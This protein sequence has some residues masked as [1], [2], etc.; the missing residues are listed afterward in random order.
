MASFHSCHSINFKSII[1]D[2]I[3]LN[4]LEGIGLDY[5]WKRVGHRL[6]CILTP[7]IITKFWSFILSTKC[8]SFYKLTT[9]LPKLKIYDRFTIVDEESG[10][11][12]EPP[13]LL[14]GPYEYCPVTGEY[15][16]CS[17]Y[18][19]RLLIPHEFIST[20]TYEEI[21]N[22]YGDM[23]VIVASLEERWIALAP[24]LPITLLPQLS[25][26][27][28]CI[29]ELVGKGREN[30]QMTVGHN[31]NLSKIVKESKLLFYNRKLLQKLD[32]VR[33][34][35]LTQ[36][37]ADR[38]MK[39]LI[40]RL[41]KFHQPIIQTQPKHG[42]IHAIAEYLRQQPNFTEKNE[43]LIR[44]GFMTPHQSKRLQKTVNI[45]RYIGE[46]KKKKNVQ[47]ISQSDE[48]SHSE[49]ES[50]EELLKC[51]YK[52]GV[53]LLRQ[54]YERF[55]D[56]GLK[57]LTQL[58]LAQLLGVE[59]YTSRTL[60]RI[61]KTKGLVREFLEDKGRQ[62]TAR[63][64]AVAATNEIDS[65]FAEEK[66]KLIDFL[67]KSRKRCH[68]ESQ[69]EVPEKKVK[70]ELK[71]PEYEESAEKELDS[72]IKEI[73]VMDGFQERD[74]ESLLDTK[75]KPTLRQLRFATGIL[76]VVKERG[77]V[78]G[79]QT[80][81]SFV[82]RE[83]GEPPMDTKSLKLVIQ[84][85]I[86]DGQ[87]KMY[88]LRVPYPD[89][90]RFWLYI[91]PPYVKKT[92]A[93]MNKY[94]NEICA[95][96]ARK[97]KHPHRKA[98]R[99]RPLTHYT[100]PRYLKIQKLHE[101][102]V[103]YVYFSNV[104]SNFT[105]G[106][107]CLHDILPEMTVEFALGNISFMS[108]TQNFSNFKTTEEVLG[109]KL[110][111]APD[112][113]KNII[114][115]SRS[116]HN[117]IK[118]GLKMLSVLGLV[119]LIK[120]PFLCAMEENVY[121]NFVIYVNKNAKL[122]DTT[123]I[124]PRP[125][126]NHA[127]LEK[128][129]HF[130]SCNDVIK[131]WDDVQSIG[132]NTTITGVKR[133]R[134]K[135]LHELR[136]ESEVFKYDV[137]MRFG[138]GLGPCGFD[139]SI[140]VDIPRLWRTYSSR[141]FKP[142]VVKVLKSKIKY[143]KGTTSGPKEEKKAGPKKRRRRAKR[144]ETKPKPKPE[145]GKIV[146]RSRATRSE[147]A[148]K[149]SKLDD[150]ILN[151]L[152]VALAIMSPVP[153]SIK[154][155]N[156]IAKTL[157]SAI[158]PGKVASL[159]HRRSIT[160]ESDTKL[161]HEKLCILNELRR[162]PNLIAKY[163]GLFK[164][165]RIRHYANLGKFIKEGKL[166]MME[167]LWIILRVAETK[168][169]IQEMPCVASN[170]EEFHN[171]YTITSTGQ[172][173]HNLYRVSGTPEPEMASLKEGIILTVMLSL[174]S[175]LPEEISKKIYSMFKLHHEHTL[176]SAIEELRKCGAISARE[177]IFNNHLHKV[178]LNDI[179]QSAYKMSYVYRRKWLNRLLSHFDENVAL[180]LHK[181]VPKDG[182]KGSSVINCL[183]LEM[184]SCG[185]IDIVSATVPAIVGSAGS[186]IQEDKLNIIDMEAR[187]TLKS[188]LIGWKNLSS[189]K[190]FSEFYQDI[191]LK[192]IISFLTGDFNI[193]DDITDENNEDDLIKY[194]NEKESEGCS[195]SELQKQTG[196]DRIT[197]YEKLKKFETDK[198]I[199]RLGYY[200]NRILL[201]KYAKPWLFKVQDNQYIIPTPWLNLDGKIRMN[202]LF[203]WASVVMNKI[204]ECP[205]A[206]IELMCDVLEY[207]TVRSVQDILV[208]LEKCGCIT[209]NC[210][211]S[212]K[213]DLF[214]DDI[215][216]ELL[217]YN[218]YE[219]PNRIIAFPIKNCITRFSYI[220][221]QILNGIKFE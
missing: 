8:V 180:F 140:F 93:T 46:E 102:I 27:H 202:I 177:K 135:L 49:D 160:L 28:F 150:H 5:L 83:T 143:K 146:R 40:L 16:S 19:T 132:L 218:C 184:Y 186:L 14:D 17:N 2:E 216:P 120:E 196:M 194:L 100:Y 87:L 67:N 221:H 111:V 53:S 214:S 107:T 211:E 104:K 126:T 203:N 123:G 191:D 58:E 115:S 13:E 66:K 175:E 206:S 161:A 4:G 63:Y 199:M 153:G 18:E 156:L 167:L 171:K 149:W 105:P 188:G 170:L 208:F 157:L 79:Y 77:F 121:L 183:L 181:D 141:N 176:R 70:Q 136:L 7:K 200:D 94:Y 99:N 173:A 78:T 213:V 217:D 152:K 48:S 42:K 142:V 98:H 85:L 101:L 215:E 76:K 15:G 190:T 163:E 166:P 147:T 44:K 88:Q 74:K 159:C 81:S 131:Y 32:L 124:W 72:K 195:F 37:Y 39:S 43:V 138:D 36:V 209:L 207:I 91:C 117:S 24:H 71:D 60:C 51:E 122:L 108:E 20:K 96:S 29:L 168:P 47:L 103:H 178:N 172:N 95:K 155:K 148:V 130:N 73:K 64:I 6:S 50:P 3:A 198:I 82:S 10:Q 54:A 114:L 69:S 219:S 205:G 89:K 56:A 61:I 12:L 127:A 106:F 65:K 134:Y 33:V 52:V 92:D 158:E 197:L 192:N 23:L 139:S 144:P 110:R 75:K 118:G 185:L 137:G 165:L 201:K 22:L 41:K 189:Y 30:G 204:F 154:I 187:Y 86:T 35:C 113:V 55:L 68:S 151:M 34:Q 220:K 80:L 116:L 133:E 182:V 31:T 145:P 57:G 193:L 9:P 169:Y 25:P 59:F 129:Y 119:Q 210:I 62:R 38:G 84:K 125:N 128:S 11:L 45:F 164:V 212:K 179:S 97:Y 21:E 90:D 174:D 162:R 109:Q 26:I 1:I 112:N